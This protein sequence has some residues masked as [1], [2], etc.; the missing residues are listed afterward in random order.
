MQFGAFV[1]IASGI[2]GLV[3]ISELAHHRVQRVSSVVQEG[4]PVQVKVLSV[5]PE[6]QKISLSIKA[7]TGAAAEVASAEDGADSDEVEA[8]PVKRRI[9]DEQLKGGLKR[10]SGGEQFGLKW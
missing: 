5:D 6:A 4:N 7:V 9:C 10:D 1:R 2:E 8:T 3:H